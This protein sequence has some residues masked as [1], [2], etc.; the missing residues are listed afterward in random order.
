VTTT[1]LQQSQLHLYV[2]QIMAVG[3]GLSR[4]QL[5]KQGGDLFTT[6]GRMNC[7]MSLASS[8]T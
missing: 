1:S 3:C 2:K 8:K 7:G 5:L 6:T 4:V